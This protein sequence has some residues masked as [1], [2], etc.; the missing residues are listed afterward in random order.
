MKRDNRERWL[1]WIVLLAV[2]VI[3]F[4]PILTAPTVRVV[5]GTGDPLFLAYIVDWVGEHLFDSDLW[6]PPFF[7]PKENVLAYSD[8][9]IGL[10]ILAMP[11]RALTDSPVVLIN[12]LSFLAF[13]LTSAAVYYWLRNLH[14]LP[15]AALA[16][17]IL[18]TFSS[19]RF[20]QLS[21][22]QLLFTPFLPLA[23]LFYDRVIRCQ[24]RKV[25]LWYGTALL[26]FQTLGTP[27]LSI[28]FVPLTV[29]WICLQI[30]LPPR[31]RDPGL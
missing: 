11:V 4:W 13:F 20:L 18:F 15:L 9:L 5:G 23:L 24:G 28:Y 31:V 26:A 10:A 29:V 17:A 1:P 8:H 3:F 30:L 14:F 6:N 7:H 21:H 25:F 12:I 27:S 2:S 19:W 22:I 16:G